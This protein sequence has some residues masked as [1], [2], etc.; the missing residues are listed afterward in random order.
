MNLL[1]LVT[2]SAA[3]NLSLGK[4]SC[5]SGGNLISAMIYEM[6]DWTQIKAKLL[7]RPSYR[8]LQAH[9]TGKVI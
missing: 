3:I 6:W 5:L 4:V 7:H 8:D 2:V 1:N 9:V